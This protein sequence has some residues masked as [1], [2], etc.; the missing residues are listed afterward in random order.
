MLCGLAMHKYSDSVLQNGAVWAAFVL[1]AIQML[2]LEPPTSRAWE[3]FD[4]IRQE[5]KGKFYALY[6]ISTLCN[7]GTM[8]L[9]SLHV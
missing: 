3:K 8:T 9:Q 2:A 7:L 4:R 6:G 1:A 5:A